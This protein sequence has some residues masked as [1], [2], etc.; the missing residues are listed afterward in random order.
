MV[1]ATRRPALVVTQ[2]AL[3]A[4]VW[5]RASCSSKSDWGFVAGIR[6]VGAAAQ[7]GTAALVL[8]SLVTGHGRQLAVPSGCTSASSACC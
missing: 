2:F 7:G 8:I 6:R 1:A 4:V 5:G 3:L